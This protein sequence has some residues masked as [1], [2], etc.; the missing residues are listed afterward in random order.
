MPKMLK[1]YLM[2]LDFNNQLCDKNEFTPY[3]FMGLVMQAKKCGLQMVTH[4]DTSVSYAIESTM[5]SHKSD[6]SNRCLVMNYV[7]AK[8]ESQNYLARLTIKHKSLPT[9]WN[10]IC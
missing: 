8:C 4:I 2:W 3:G 1:D 9:N 5:D 10:N 6:S 7:A